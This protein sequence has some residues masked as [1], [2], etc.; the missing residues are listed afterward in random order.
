[1]LIE[2]QQVNDK[3]SIRVGS[4][5]TWPAAHS[6]AQSGSE[7]CGRHTPA[8]VSPAVFDTVH[9]ISFCFQNPVVAMFDA[10]FF[11][12]DLTIYAATPPD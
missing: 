4:H 5:V 9:L 3:S 6:L 8:R 12:A 2:E 11:I 10:M 1:M 7:Q